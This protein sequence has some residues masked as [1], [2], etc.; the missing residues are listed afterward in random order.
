MSDESY[1]AR[2]AKEIYAAG[3]KRVATT[4]EPKGQ[5]FPNGSRVRVG[6]MPTHM[7]HFRGECNATVR[8]TYAHAYGGSDVKSYCLDIDGYG[9]AGWYKEQQLTAISGENKGNQ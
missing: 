1:Y 4:P 2:R 3:L 9:V 8:Y 6:K 7:A 5:K